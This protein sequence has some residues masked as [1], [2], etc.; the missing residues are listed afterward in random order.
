VLRIT[1]QQAVRQPRQTL[2]RISQALGETEP[3]G[4]R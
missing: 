3:K 1:W 4:A 2:A